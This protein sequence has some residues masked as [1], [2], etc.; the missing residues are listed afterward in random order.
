MKMSQ[1]EYTSVLL[2]LLRRHRIEAVR[3]DGESGEEMNARLDARFRDSV[4][5]LTL[6]MNKIYDIK[7]DQGGLPLRLVRR[8]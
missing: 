2:A 3:L 1:V 7:D 6:Q 5:I 8:K 4:S